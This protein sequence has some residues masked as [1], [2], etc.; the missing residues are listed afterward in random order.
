M[1]QPLEDAGKLETLRRVRQRIGGV[2]SFA[3]QTG[4]TKNNPIRDMQGA[5]Q[6][7]DRANLVRAGGDRDHH[8]RRDVG[9]AG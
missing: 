5:F 9:N 6:A 1:L 8:Q 4:Y 7:F 2:L 3:V